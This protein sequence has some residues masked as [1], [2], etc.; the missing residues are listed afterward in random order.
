MSN[1]NINKCN[2]IVGNIIILSEYCCLFRKQKCVTA[3]LMQGMRLREI[4]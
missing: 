1:N 2:T 3:R 4:I